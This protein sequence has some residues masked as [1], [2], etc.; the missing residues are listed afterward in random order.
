MSTARPCASVKTFGSNA[1]NYRRHWRTVCDERCIF[2]GRGSSSPRVRGPSRPVAQ[3][4]RGRSACPVQQAQLQSL[5]DAITEVTEL[6]EADQETVAYSREE[7]TGRRARCRTARDAA[8]PA[9]H[10]PGPGTDRLGGA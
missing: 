3:P 5:S 4:R 6:S 9:R 1:K 2:G 10:L 7:R 8:G